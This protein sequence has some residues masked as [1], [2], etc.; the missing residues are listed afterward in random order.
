[1]EQTI[2]IADFA[3][4]KAKNAGRNRAVYI[5]MKDIDDNNMEEAKK[6]LLGLSKSSKLDDDFISVE[7]ITV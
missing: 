7:Y 3:L 5:S 1:M 4:Y 2:N 6:Y